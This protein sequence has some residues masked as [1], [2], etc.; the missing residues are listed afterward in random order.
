MTIFE[1][2]LIDK[3]YLE[4]TF[5]CKTM[6]YEIGHKIISTM[7]NLDQRYIHKDNRLM[8]DKINLGIS[9]LDDS[10]PFECLKGEIAFG[11]N[12]ANKPPTLLYPRPRIEIKRMLDGVIVCEDQCKDDNMNLVLMAMPFEQIFEAMF[13][14]SILIQIDL[15]HNND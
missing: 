3:G 10:F 15:T 13:D 1:L 2:E 6:K 5:N 9:I 7:V 11:L 12:E 4:F 14:R 8:L